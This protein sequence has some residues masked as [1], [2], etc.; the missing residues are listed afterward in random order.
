MAASSRL[1]FALLIVTVLA[2]CR[3]KSATVAEQQALVSRGGFSG[4]APAWS[5]R[6][7]D[8]SAAGIP[9]RDSGGIPE[10][11]N[12]PAV[13]YGANSDNDQFF[14]QVQK[15][16]AKLIET[17]AGGD[18]EE[19]IVV[20][21]D[22]ESSPLDRI[23]KVCPGIDAEAEEA[24]LIENSAVRIQKYQELTRRCP[25]SADLWTWLSRDQ[26]SSG[27]FTEAESAARQ[28]LAVQ[29]EFKPAQTILDK[30]TGQ[31]AGQGQ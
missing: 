22:K 21:R 20:N 27:N 26:L 5:P 18:E 3:F 23:A 9:L 15:S 28:A 25:L 30:I 11:F 24:I 8:G 17:Q 10:R 14:K 1:I 2:G 13:S 16:R 7:V 12:S 19:G 4:G 29:P 31:N 6:T